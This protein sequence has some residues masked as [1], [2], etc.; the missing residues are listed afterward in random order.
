MDLFTMGGWDTKAGD[1]RK[2]LLTRLYLAPNVVCSGESVMVRNFIYR[3]RLVV[4]G[5][6]AVA[7]LTGCSNERVNGSSPYQVPKHLDDGWETASLADAGFDSQKLA[8][9]IEDIQDGGFENLHSLL[10]VKDGRLVF[11]EYFR[12]HNPASID[13]V[14]SVTKSITSIM[15]GV[16]IDQGLIEG[17]D[18]YLVEL[19]QS[20]AQV[21]NADP[22]K[23]KLQLW[24]ILSM[25]SGIEWDEETYPYGSLQNDATLMERHPDPVQF[26]LDRPVIREPGEQFHYSGANSMLLSAVLQQTTGMTVA[27][28]TRVYLFEPLGINQYHWDAYADGHTNTDGGLS[29]HPR[30]MAK[31][32]QLMLNQGQWNG[33]QIV[34]PGW[35]A[36]STRAHTRVMF[37]VQ[38]GY[39]W[40]REKQTILLQ[41]V[42]PYFAAG[43][44]GQ[45]I[46]VYPDQDMVVVVTGK[47]ANHDEN[48][49]RYMFLRG[50]YI[51]PATISDLASKIILWGWYLLT[52]GSMVAVVLDI[53]Q[54]R[55]QGLGSVYW[56]LITA[57]LGPLG[58]GVY[59]LSLRNRRTRKAPGWKALGISAF[60]AAGNIAGTILLAVFQ[61]LFLPE[62]SMI[63]LLIP[64]SFLVTW[65]AFIAPLVVTTRGLPYRDAVRKTL[66]T[67]FISACFALAGIFPVLILLSFRWQGIE[68]TILLLWT[69]MTAC[70]LAGAVVVYPFNLWMV[71][72]KLD[73]WPNGQ[74]I[75]DGLK[76]ESLD[77]RLLGFRDAWGAFLLGLIL[78]IAVFGFLIMNLS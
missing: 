54:K 67:A 41:T 39:Q 18:Q 26:I 57:L 69:M 59:Y 28:Y 35:V 43:Y 70:S 53:V 77:K 14:A 38:Y 21:I 30:D 56:L 68:L 31:I 37:S 48:S 42:E 74:V 51:L 4:L 6:I 13:D 49:A 71:C 32:G 25:T 58:I 46:T 10:I 8:A 36:E 72:H 78:M 55:F 9:M 50:T 23:Q 60:I 19:L 20:Y 73:F 61:A 47:T 1:T 2:A 16:A 63:L 45:L 15:V 17:T 65:L 29:L 22:L 75:G 24:H 33:V 7:I 27:E 76:P 12:G 44:G 62:G 52:L 64:V 66:L 5:I 11:E 3:F 40:W 34:S